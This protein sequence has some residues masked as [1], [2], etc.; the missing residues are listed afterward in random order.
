[1]NYQITH[2]KI[3]KDLFIK[4]K[5]ACDDDGRPMTRVIRWLIKTWLK[6]REN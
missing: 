6:S 2:Y 4:F 3:P 1:M 5:K